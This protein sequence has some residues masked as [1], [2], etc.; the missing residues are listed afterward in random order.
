MTK[1]LNMIRLAF[2]FFMIPCFCLSQDQGLELRYRHAIY[3]DGQLKDNK[4][5]TGFINSFQFASIVFVKENYNSESIVLIHKDTILHQLK[6]LA[7]TEFHS[8]SY[9]VGK[10]SNYVNTLTGEKIPI[11]ND[12]S[13]YDIPDLMGKLKPKKYSQEE[14]TDCNISYFVAK[15]ESKKLE[16]KVCSNIKNKKLKSGLAS[17]FFYKDMLIKEL[18]VIDKEK[19]EELVR[20]LV[21][22]K[23][24]EQ[25]I[26]LM[27]SSTIETRLEQLNQKI[28]LD[29]IEFG[30]AIPDI[31][32]KNVEADELIN[33]NDY[34]GNG[35]YLLVDFWGTWCKP[36]IASIPKLK[37]FHE[38]YKDRV[39]ILA[40]NYSDGSLS[41][42]RAI[43]KKTGMTW[44][45]GIASKRVNDILNPEIHFPGIIL[46]DDEMKL[47]VRDN[48]KVA[49]QKTKEILDQLRK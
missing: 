27:R 6:I 25:A 44:Y 24:L 35:K 47:L 45:Q 13:F 21:E 19:N 1:Y 14:N 49:L 11:K 26:H 42:I 38:Q 28:K 22:I 33:L 29:S 37:A 15:Q 41:K 32:Y 9:Q 18:R 46:F 43:I 34:K 20:E 40:M 31:Y 3:K 39:D 16:L 7:D 12:F 36:C 48:A 17:D 4:L 8:T 5:R 10:E 30:V 23:N 2:L